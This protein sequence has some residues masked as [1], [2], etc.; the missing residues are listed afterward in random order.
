[1]IQPFILIAKN[2]N[3]FIQNME[4]KGSYLTVSVKALHFE[5]PGKWFLQLTTIECPA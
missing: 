1:M 5:G 3:L 4:G 2:H